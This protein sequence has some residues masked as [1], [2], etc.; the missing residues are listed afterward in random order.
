MLMVAV[1]LALRLPSTL[2]LV[3]RAMPADV[4]ANVGDP[5]LVD[6]AVRIGALLGLALT[7]ISALVF[8]GLAA[9]LERHAPSAVLGAGRLR[10]G[11]C[12]ATVGACYLVIQVRGLLTPPSV[13]PGPMPVVLALTTGLLVGLGYAW[14]ARGS[15]TARRV[16]AGVLATTGLA[17]AMSLTTLSV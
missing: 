3:G 12:T 10:L 14:R 15:A 2:D 9:L 8:L 1:L 17:L 13:H 11:A 4:V 16:V 5:H 7:L 6:L